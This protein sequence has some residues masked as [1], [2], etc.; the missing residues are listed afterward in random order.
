M[1][2]KKSTIRPSEYFL[3][4]IEVAHLIHVGDIDGFGV[5]N[6]KDVKTCYVLV[7]QGQSDKACFIL[8]DSELLLF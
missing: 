6:V 2:F 4:M 7:K 3:P 1:L 5:Y 8:F